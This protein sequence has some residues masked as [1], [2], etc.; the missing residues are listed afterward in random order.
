MRSRDRGMTWEEV[1]G[2]DLT[3]QID[4]DELE[5]MGVSGTEPMMSLHDGISTYGNLTSF[6]ESPLEPRRA[7]TSVRTTATCRCQPRRR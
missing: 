4:R 6:A 2:L 7:S 5:I 3:K 1:G